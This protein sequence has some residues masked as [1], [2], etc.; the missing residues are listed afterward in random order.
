M[1]FGGTLDDVLSI[2]RLER[3]SRHRMSR[4]RI[5]DVASG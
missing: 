2:Q 5:G 3:L 1:G 4:D